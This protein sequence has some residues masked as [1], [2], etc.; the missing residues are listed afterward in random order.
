MTKNALVL[1]AFD[2]VYVNFDMGPSRAEMEP[3]RGTARGEN[4]KAR[5]KNTKHSSIRNCAQLPIESEP[6][7]TYRLFLRGPDWRFRKNDRR[8]RRSEFHFAKIFQA[9]RNLI[10]YRRRFVFDE[11]IFHTALF[12]SFQNCWPIDD[13]SSNWNIV[14]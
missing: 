6:T 13:A 9:H 5:L 12:G 7:K 8:E 3:V 10:L 14:R 11:V 4:M 2:K 1:R